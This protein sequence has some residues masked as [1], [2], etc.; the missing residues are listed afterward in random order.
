MKNIYYILIV[1]QIIL[2]DY[3]EDLFSLR[4]NN[5]KI[6]T[7]YQIKDYNLTVM[8]ISLLTI[9][10][11]FIIEEKLLRRYKHIYINKYFYYS[12]MVFKVLVILHFNLMVDPSKRIWNIEDIH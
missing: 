2:L 5:E 9:S 10:T 4:F 1:V 12:Y 11:L 8:I 6:G 3:I 7:N